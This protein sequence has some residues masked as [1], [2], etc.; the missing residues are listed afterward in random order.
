MLYLNIVSLLNVPMYHSL[1]RVRP[2]AMGIRCTVFFLP[3]FMI[4]NICIIYFHIYFAYRFI[5]KIS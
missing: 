5:N 1:K 4:Y 3:T 2:L